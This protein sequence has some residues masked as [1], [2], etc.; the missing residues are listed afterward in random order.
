MQKLSVPS[1]S[2][3]LPDFPS[4]YS[5][6]CRF[7]QYFRDKVE[8]LRNDLDHPNKPY[9][10]S[11][12]ATS[13]PAR[14]NEFSNVN[15]TDIEALLTKSK[16]K[17]CTLDPIPTSILKQCIDPLKWH[18]ATIVNYSIR[19]SIFPGNLKQAI[20]VPLLK[21][22]SLDH[23]ELSNY[24]PIANLPFL[25]KVL[26]KIIYMQLDNYLTRNNLYPLMQSG[27]RKHH[28]TETILIKLFNEIGCLLDEGRNSVLTLLDLSS[29][30]DTV[31]HDILLERLQSRFGLTGSVLY[32][33]KSYFTQ[34]SEVVCINGTPSK[35]QSVNYGVPQGSI[36]GPLLFNL[37]ISP[38]EDI[39]HAHALSILSYADDTQLYLSLSS[40]TIEESLLHLENCLSDLSSWFSSN[41]LTCNPLKTNLIYFSSITYHLQNPLWLLSDLPKQSH[42][43]FTQ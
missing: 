11:I 3:T 12:R 28:S 15:V 43:P 2:N 13:C 6:A 21:K 24:R 36:L 9:S 14:L 17:H 4:D 16:T 29:A 8:T 38:I 39:V 5:L 33:I 18:I 37:Y 20:I 1:R 40:S 25:S 41:K 34:R 19:Q 31:D 10:V 26:E 30:F 27:Y 22:S 35:S 7:S 42:L 32:W 23:N